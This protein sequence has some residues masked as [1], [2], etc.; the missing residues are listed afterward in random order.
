MKNP[1]DPIGNRT[2]ERLAC[3]AMPQPTACP[4]SKNKRMSKLYLIIRSHEDVSTNSARTACIQNTGAILYRHS[5]TRIGK[6]TYEGGDML[7][8]NVCIH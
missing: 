4:L 3:G 5:R 6:Q 1:S 7:M 8:Q 2:H